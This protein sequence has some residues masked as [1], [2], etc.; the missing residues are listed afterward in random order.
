MV[1][2]IKVQWYWIWFLMKIGK[3]KTHAWMG[4]V[5]LS[6]IDD[7]CNDQLNS[8]L[9]IGDEFQLS[10]VRINITCTEHWE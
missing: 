10:H 9:D 8:N 7:S 5:R 1:H 2:D 6:R 3:G 4:W